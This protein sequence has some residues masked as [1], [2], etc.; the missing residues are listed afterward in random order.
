M[1]ASLFLVAYLASLGLTATSGLLFL[2]KRVPLR[3]VRVHV[4][5]FTI[6]FLTAVAALIMATG[7]P[8][9]GPFAPTRLGWVIAAYVALL[10]LVVEKFSVRYLLGAL[11]YRQYFFTL[12]LVLGILAELWLTNDLRW[13][14]AGWTGVV[15]G[16]SVLQWLTN[17]GREALLAST[18]T[19]VTLG[20]GAAALLGAAVWLHAAT[21]AWSLAEAFRFLAHEHTHFTF[22]LVLDGLLVV[23]AVAPAAQWPFQRWLLDSVAAPTPISAVMHAGFVNMGG[24]LLARF[25]PVFHSDFAIW[26]LFAVATLSIFRGAGVALV[27]ADYKRQLIGSTM[28]QMGF[29]LLQC[30]LGAYTAAILHLILH[31]FFKSTLFLQSGSAVPKRTTAGSATR[32]SLMSLPGVF[33]VLVGTLTAILYAVLAGSYRGDIVSATL[34][35]WSVTLAL[36]QL[37]IAPRQG[38][39]RFLGTGLV[40]GAVTAFL[41]IHI[42]VA[43]LLLGSVPNTSP[44]PGTSVM[45][46]VF[47]V[48]AI[49]GWLGLALTRQFAPAIASR[50]YL[51]LVWLGEPSR[52][53]FVSAVPRVRSPEPKL[54]TSTI[55]QM[56]ERSANVT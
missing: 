25:S 37:W 19:L 36:Q 26:L 32:P 5:L 45:T 33:A 44:S 18:E 22:S 16:L 21:H 27:H 6:P 9:V 17:R 15:L 7:S 56:R 49:T 35:G 51:W 38:S 28:A 10:A 14:V 40:T 12:T 39:L 43:E 46:T 30:A 47:L 8:H 54:S 50:L 41:F 48:V 31:G 23:A 52:S 20:I 55:R 13:L 3:Y 2:S 11:V 34:L 53:V 24:I 4:N 42:G 29:M 1:N